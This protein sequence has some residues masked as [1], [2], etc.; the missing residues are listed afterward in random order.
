MD[1]CQYNTRTKVYKRL[2][3]IL[4]G[5]Q[6]FRCLECQGVANT[7]L[8][9]CDNCFDA[10]PWH[11]DY[12]RHCGV[13]L[14][15]ALLAQGFKS[16]GHC[17][18]LDETPFDRVHVAFHFEDPVRDW[19]NQLKFH[20]QLSYSKLFANA[21]ADLMSR[22]QVNPSM[23]VIPMPLHW[24]RLNE[25]GYNQAALVAKPLAQKLGIAYCD[26]TLKRRKDTPHQIG[27]SKAKRQHNVRAAFHC[28]KPAASHIL[29]VDDVM[30]TGSTA[31]AAARCLKRAGA[32][33]I[34]LAL[35]A[36]AG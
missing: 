5:L 27:L 3:N 31:Y 35:I 36:R 13:A 9:L 25:R 6:L 33:H 17:I 21:L 18:V 15:D 29:L 11:R 7:S 24:R 1:D 14:T 4:A 16:C 23:R 32:Q 30:T 10:L 2:K 20:Q 12:C 22:Q 34:E 8:R 26:H 19:I 28:V